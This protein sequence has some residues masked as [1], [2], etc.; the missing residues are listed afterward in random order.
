[1]VT[2]YI[3]WW[4]NVGQIIAV[5]YHDISYHNHHCVPNAAWNEQTDIIPFELCIYLY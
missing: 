2:I 3:V 4:E 5:V 1:M